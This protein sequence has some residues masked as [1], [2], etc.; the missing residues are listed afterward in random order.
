[1][2]VLDPSSVR[3]VTV[4][5][6]QTAFRMATRAWGDL[7]VV[8]PLVGH[9][10]AVNTALAIEIFEQ[11]PSGL[12]PD[13]RA[14]TAGIHD[15]R[16]PGR[17]EVRVVGGTTWLLDVAHNTAGVAS[18]VDTLPRLALP[19]PWVALIGVLGDKDW[20]GMLPPVL[21]RVDA[22]VLTVPRSAPPGRRW[23]PAEA[24]SVL[25]GLAVP[26]RGG[27]GEGSAGDAPSGAASE[28]L[29][30]EDF[31]RALR[32][33]GQRAGAGTVI[34]TGSVH[35]VGNAMAALGIDPLA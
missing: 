18:L 15:V 29:V 10:Q 7:E 35:T 14:L 23:D 5:R 30:V 12:R 25:R 27:G 21:A 11:L 33:A 8:T 22:A 26:S 9:H 3:D 28:V 4:A 31:E 13:A 24:A 17:D 16:H 6:G 19:R 20:R 32:E 34:V 2:S 1:V